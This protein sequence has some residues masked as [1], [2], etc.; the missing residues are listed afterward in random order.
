[1]NLTDQQVDKITR[2]IGASPI[3]RAHMRDD[4]VDHLCCAVELRMTGGTDFEKALPDALYELA[5]N[6]LREIDAKLFYPVASTNR[7]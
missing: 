2:T 6:G 3:S 1:M 5:P 4:L 7:G